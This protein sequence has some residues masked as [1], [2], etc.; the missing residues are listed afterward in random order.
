MENYN[1][2]NIISEK[3]KI[4]Y[5]INELVKNLSENNLQL[6]PDYNQRIEVLKFL[7]YIDDNLTVQLKGKIACE[8]CIIIF[9]KISN[10]YLNNIK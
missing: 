3:K 5:K 6:L 1:Q 8:V 9:Y 2:Y 10:K 4:E 7:R